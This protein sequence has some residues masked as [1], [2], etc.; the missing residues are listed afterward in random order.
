[1]TLD[2]GPADGALVGRDRELAAGE[3]LLGRASQAGG[4]VLLLRGSAGIGKTTLLDAVRARAAKRGFRVLVTAGSEAETAFAFAALQPLLL[5]VIDSDTGLPEH[6]RTALL[7]ALGLVDAEIPALETVGLAVLG[8]LAGL[9][10]EATPLCLVV[11]DTHW[12]DTSTAAVLHFVARRLSA[13]PVVLLAAGRDGGWPPA[14]ALPELRIEPLDLAAAETLLA[15]R[16]PAMPAPTRQRVLAEAA[17][18]PLGLVELSAAVAAAQ[19]DGSRALPEVLPLTARLEAAF[20]GR[21]GSMSAA[22]RAALLVAALAPAAGTAEVLAAASALTGTPVDLSALDAAADERL[23]DVVG[24]QVQFRHPLVR[25]GVVQAAAPSARRAAH[26]ALA[27]VLHDPQRRL[28]HR[29]EATVGY[30]DELASELEAEAELAVRRGSLAAGVRSL[31]QAAALTTP[32]PRRGGRLVRAA[33]LS[34]ELGQADETRRLLALAGRGELAWAEQIAARRLAVAV[35]GPDTDDPERA[36]ELLAFAE[37]VLAAGDASGALDLLVFTSSQLAWGKQWL[38]VGRAVVAAAHRVPASENDLRVI[39]V[40][41]QA[42]PVLA[43]RELTARLEKVADAQ[44]TDAAAQQLIGFVAVITADYDRGTRLLDRAEQQLRRDARLAQLGLVLTFRGIAAFSAGQWRLAEQVLDEAE[45]LT[46]DTV[47]PSWQHRASY[48]RAGIAGLTGDEE[49]H[50]QIIDELAAR[51][52]RTRA[53]HRD[54]HLTFMQGITATM[55]GRHDDAL[56][57]LG[58]LFDPD[59]PMFE[60]RTGYDALFYLADS[61]VAKGRADLVQR[62][63]GVMA[64]TVP[65]PW[66]APLRAAADYARAVTA[67]EAETGPLLEAALGGPAG[68][69]AFDRARVQ[70]AYG[71]WL[72]HHYQQMKAREQLREARDIFDRLG[73]DP[74]ASRSRDELRAAGEASHKRRSAAWDELSPQ[75]LQIAQLVAEGLSNK[76][77]GERLFLSHRT[78]ASHLYRIF[79]KLGVTSRAQLVAALKSI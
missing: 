25:S 59:D 56:A 39:A 8:L 73:N 69:R 38:E 30:D 40:I 72:R 13:D 62:A 26:Q 15:T 71:R 70:L 5:P 65:A 2:L 66:P 35:D 24:Q 28:H 32:V 79:P 74:F 68:D 49:R 21:A 78:I 58:A 4:G 47:Q 45:R 60:A 36:W 57:L 44:L 18:N 34:F 3:E 31:D 75:E 33:Q 43:H 48:T 12:L 54:N 29:A 52:Q 16:S 17:G 67:S 63:L 20:A 55:A 9:A 50:R 11:D 7:S 23:V 41:A 14:G 51:F 27:R 6:L 53:S 61:A 42:Q 1:V 77:V 19:R 37:E 46:A 76:Q 10:T 22:T 64:A